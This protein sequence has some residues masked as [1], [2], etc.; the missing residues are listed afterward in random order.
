MFAPNC[1][2]LQPEDIL[3]RRIYELIRPRYVQEMI[4]I[5]RPRR[6]G[7]GD[8]SVV[9]ECRETV[10]FLLHELAR[11]ENLDTAGV[12]R[13]LAEYRCLIPQPGN[14]TATLFI[15]GGSAE[16]GARLAQRISA[17][18]DVV[19]LHLGSQRIRARVTAP[20]ADPACPVHY[21]GFTVSDAHRRLL[22]DSS[23]AAA[24]E[25][26]EPHGRHVQRLGW[27]TRLALSQD[28]RGPWF[29][30]P[31]MATLLTLTAG[32]MSVAG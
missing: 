32:Q 8:V 24:L 14:V 1:P 10:L 31:I 20:A 17:G 26:I 21:L 15:D 12:A 30:P 11:A 23:A 29:R 25:L 27:D 16:W 3:P 19:G 7:L 4:A 9:F 2:T 6:V 22:L 28:L 13:C 5:K 18:D